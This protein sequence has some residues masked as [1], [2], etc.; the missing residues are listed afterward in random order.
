[1]FVER[2]HCCRPSVEHSKPLRKYIFKET[3][4][5]PLTTQDPALPMDFLQALQMTHSTWNFPKEQEAIP[6]VMGLEQ[7]SV[8]DA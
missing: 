7:A 5:T 1:M 3:A 4:K 6:P 2:L 8:Q